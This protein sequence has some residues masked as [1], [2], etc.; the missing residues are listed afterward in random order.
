MDPIIGG[1]APRVGPYSEYYY[2]VH[3]AGTVISYILFDLATYGKQHR[4]SILLRPRHARGT[5]THTRLSGF[6]R[7]ILGFV[8]AHDTVCQCRLFTVYSLQARWYRRL[9]AE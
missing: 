5:G 1:I 2:G 4:T 3:N 9:R 7:E 8:D 6:P